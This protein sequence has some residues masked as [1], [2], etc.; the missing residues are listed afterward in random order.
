MLEDYIKSLLVGAPT[1]ASLAVL[2]TALLLAGC[3]G[4]ET[5][6]D[7]SGVTE[8]TEEVGTAYESSF[9]DS[10]GEADDPALTDEFDL[11]VAKGTSSGDVLYGSKA[12][13]VGDASS[14]VAPEATSVTAVAKSTA[15]VSAKATA[16]PVV[17]WTGKGTG[18]YITLTP[19]T[20]RDATRLMDQASFGAAKSASTNI[21]KY[22]VER[23]IGLQML[24]KVSA[25]TKGGSSAIHTYGAR[26][27]FCELPT[28][29]N[30][31][32]CWRN[33]YSHVP[34][35]LD[36]YRNATYR[37][38][39]LRQRVAFAYQQIF[40]VSTYEINAVYGMRF[41]HNA[42]L[43]GAFDNYRDI[44]RRVILSPV[45][46]DYLDH[47]NNDKDEP[48]EN[49]AR[50]L[51]QLFSIGTCELNADGT[52]KTGACV[53]TYDNEMVRNY[54]YALTGWTY[55]KGGKN[56]WG[57]WPKGANCTYYY[58]YM[59]PV[60][61]FHNVD[62]RTLLS[63]VELAEG[64]TSLQ[65][66]E[67]VLD[68]IMA[69]PNTA[70]FMSRQLI[71]KLVTSNPSPA[72]VQR[73]SQAFQSGSF[74][75]FGT[76]KAGDMRAVI[77]A[78]LLDEEARQEVPANDF[79]RLREPVHFQTGVIRTMGGYTDGVPFVWEWADPQPVFQ[80]PSV[81]NFYPPDYPLPGDGDLYG[82][83]FAI[84]NAN[85]ALDR[86]NFLN[87]L[88]FWGGYGKDKGFGGALG[89]AV[90]YPT[91]IKLAE[92]PEALVDEIS[93]RALGEPLPAADRANVI[94]AVEGIEIPSWVSK[95][96]RP[97][98]L[99]RRIRQAAYLVFA[100]PNYQMI[101]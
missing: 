60:E 21:A 68:S 35:V 36:F 63:G 16:K 97:E 19:T 93:N 87:R 18:G 50:E 75:G 62:A 92:T 25:Y 58:G 84:F 100:S 4:G 71:Q 57:C 61:A 85:S 48:N 55:P 69:H 14:D 65:A 72:Y 101:R 32:N 52:L 70:P 64:S 59:K 49:F 28:Q 2:G 98:Y 9:A 17:K 7:K 95:K 77:A 31:K 44:L 6:A 45:M 94:A 53:P 10:V 20:L 67:K 82:P 56:Y 78:I 76:G 3:G 46:G 91:F 86:M 51:L 11:M 39:Q 27:G 96:D 79:G 73:V 24:N 26:K 81:F 12:L 38:D 47:V 5:S 13:A 15:T 80:S 23:W 99:K 33:Y 34:L 30:N 90:S 89:T 29:V 8:D 54:A 88:L 40:V 1:Y 41:Y 66:L 74:K 43:K 42:L 22:G 37:S 83:E